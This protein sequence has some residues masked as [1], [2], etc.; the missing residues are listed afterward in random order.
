MDDLNIGEKLQRYRTMRHMT[1][2]ELSAESGL[3]P[4]ML[5]QI[6]RGVTNPS[7]NTLRTIAKALD[8]PLYHFFKEDA[9]QQDP[10]VRAGQ[11]KSIGLPGYEV[12]YDLLTPDTS[13]SLE[14]CLMSIPAGGS[15]SERTMSHTGEEV[16]LVL[17]GEVCLHVEEKRYT[18]GEGDSIRIPPQ[19][20][21]RWTNP[22]PGETTIVFAV[23]PPSF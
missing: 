14:V 1:M 6:E 5:S 21:H 3:T 2:R 9:Q 8:V 4:S 18:L 7:I 20:D 16:A 12:T 17:K 13:G 19:A 22:G 15:S 10:V 11:R 23:T